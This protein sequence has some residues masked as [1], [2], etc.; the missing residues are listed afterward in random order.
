MLFVWTTFSRGTKWPKAGSVGGSGTRW[1]FDDKTGAHFCEFTRRRSC[2]RAFPTDFPSF[3]PGFVRAP[4]LHVLGGCQ[5]DERTKFGA[6]DRPGV[7]VTCFV[8]PLINSRSYP[9]TFHDHAWARCEISFIYAII[10]AHGRRLF[11]FS[12]RHCCTR[13]PARHSTA[14]IDDN[15]GVVSFSF[16]VFF[17]RT[18]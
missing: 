18:V 3:V 11:F 4:I 2:A 17:Q 9:R 16:I 6:T 12:T 8:L 7:P 15:S 14:S 1:F 5:T 13:F 10:N